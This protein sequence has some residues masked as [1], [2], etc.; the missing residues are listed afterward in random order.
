MPLQE[1]VTIQAV[2]VLWDLQD[3]SLDRAFLPV[4]CGSQWAE[5]TL[6]PSFS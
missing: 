6:R 5:A 3:L 2:E 4:L 1:W